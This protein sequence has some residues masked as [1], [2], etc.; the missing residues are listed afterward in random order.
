MS[1]TTCDI[2]LYVGRWSPRINRSLR[3]SFDQAVRGAVSVEI[4]VNEDGDGPRLQATVTLP[5]A[6]GEA[7]REGLEQDLLHYLR[8]QYA[9]Q[10]EV[11]IADERVDG[12]VAAFL[13]Q[14]GNNDDDDDDDF[15]SYGI[16]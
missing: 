14:Q 13:M 10:I 12:D 5:S 8:P 15:E 3:R 2:A 1:Q 7:V 4:T 9:S 16:H 6:D 11:E